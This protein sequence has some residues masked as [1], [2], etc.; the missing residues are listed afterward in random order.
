MNTDLRAPKLF[1]KVNVNSVLLDGIVTELDVCPK[2]EN[3]QILIPKEALALIGISSDCDYVKFDDISGIHKHYDTMGLIFLDEDEYVTGINRDENLPYM[4]SLS[5]SI[6]FKIPRIKLTG[7]Y[8]P[9]TDEERESFMVVGQQIADMIEERNVQ[10]PHLFAS[11]DVFDRL[12]EIYESKDGSKEYNRI[13]EIIEENKRYRA[14]WPEI[15]PDGS[16][17]ATEAR[18]SGY[19]ETE[20]DVGGRHSD[21]ENRLIEIK[22]M[23]FVARITGDV[24]MARASYYAC[25][26]IIGRKHWGPGHFLNCAGATASL[27][28]IYDWLFDMWVELGLDTGAIKRGIYTQGMH[29]GFNSVIYDTCDIPSPQQGTGWRFKAKPDNWNAVCNGGMI[30]GALCLLAEGVDENLSTE[31]YMKVKELIGACLTSVMQDH[32]V[33]KQ[34]APDGSYVESNSYWSYGTGRLFQIMG[35]LHSTIGTDLGMHNGCGLD[36]TCYYAINTESAEFV[37]WN[38]HDG[39]LSSQDTTTFNMYATVSGDKNLYAIREMHLSCGKSANIMDL[40]YCPRVLG[41]EMPTL[42]ELPLDYFMEGIDAFTVRSGWEKGSVFAGM[43]GGVNAIGGSHNQLDSG[44]FV[45][46]NLGKMWITDLGADNYNCG[47]NKNGE[48]YFSNYGLYRRNAEGAN[49]VVVKSLPFGQLLGKRGRLTQHYSSDTNSYCVIDNTPVYG[50][51]ITESAK[52]G[53]LFTG[54]RKTLVIADEI[55]F[56][57]PECAYWIAHFESDKISASISPDGKSCTLTHTD[58]E[59]ISIRAIG[60]GAAF[61]VLSCYDFLLSGTETIEG[62]HSRENHSRLVIKYENVNEICLSVVIEAKSSDA[63]TKHLPISS[64]EELK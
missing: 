29:H 64:W 1:M 44:S 40:L 48:G 37:G 23:A 21:S 10:H 43:M 42:G 15:L 13:L 16:G 17:F 12:K 20:Y 41:I 60:D 61:E 4:L 6:C 51:D 2:N 50:E 53:M 31:E 56:K 27:A 54:N 46:H 63:Y 14:L 49:T 55:K 45:Y 25:L 9:A 32:L 39:H 58:G 11:R 62:E 52:R 34:Y 18:Q 3:G 8:S 24:D 26:S 57:K 28:V 35:A 5:N 36:K 22:I 30:V 33:F 38:Y 19:G 47:K 7:G 59:S